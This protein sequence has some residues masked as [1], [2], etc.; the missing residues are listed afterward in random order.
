[1]A[2]SSTRRI[3]AKAEDSTS[4]IVPK[5]LQRGQTIP[6]VSP[7]DGLRRWRD[8]SSRPNLD[9][10]PTWTL[11]RSTSSASRILFSTA[12]WFLGEFMSIKSMTTRPPMSL[13][14]ICRHISSAASRFVFKAV[15][16]ISAP[17]VALDELISIDTSA[18]VGSMTTE[19]P[20]GR[21]TSLWKADS[22]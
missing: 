9:M 15:S 21:R 3:I 10:R 8:I 17:L 12:R 5:P 14:R 1:M 11:A 2:S 4:R 22:I 6:L 13:R 7:N 16:S 18:S 19:P 20:D